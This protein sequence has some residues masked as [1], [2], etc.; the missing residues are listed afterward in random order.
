[1]ATPSFALF[2]TAG[3]QHVATLFGG[4]RSLLRFRVVWGLL[5][6]AVTV[7]LF[8]YDERGGLEAGQ[9]RL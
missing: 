4:A 6:A 7:P 8:L 1:M 5:W 3:P 9:V 2:G